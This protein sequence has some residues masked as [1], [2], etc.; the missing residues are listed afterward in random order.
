MIKAKLDYRFKY[1]LF[2]I[3]VSYDSEEREYIGTLKYL[4]YIYLIHLI[5]FSFKVHETGI[6]EY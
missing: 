3:L 1:L 4:K 2:H 6:I 5:P